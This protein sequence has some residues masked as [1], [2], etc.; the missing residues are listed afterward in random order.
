MQITHFLLTIMEHLSQNKQ[1][2]IC[3]TV[4]GEAQIQMYALQSFVI[5]EIQVI[6]ILTIFLKHLFKHHLQSS[7]ATSAALPD[8]D[9]FTHT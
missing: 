2:I 5:G 1:F 9:C 7:E 6:D 3:Q 4:H 8:G